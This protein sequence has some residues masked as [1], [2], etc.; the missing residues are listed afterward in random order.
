MWEVIAAV[1]MLVAAFAIALHLLR[2][3]GSY[4]G[5]LFGARVAGLVGEINLAKAG[6]VTRKLLVYRLV[7]GQAAEVGIELQAR[8]L[9]SFQQEAIPMTK[10]EARRLAELLVKAAG[11]RPAAD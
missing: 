10:A 6:Y 2:T 11:G 8:A 1:G 7:P 4:K 9:G 5:V 3:H